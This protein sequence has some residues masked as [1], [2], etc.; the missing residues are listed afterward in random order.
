MNWQDRLNPQAGGA[1][2]HLHE[3]FGRIAR[4]HQV[5]L[6]VSRWPGAPAR[7]QVDGMDV[8]RAGGRYTFTFAGPWYYRRRLRDQGFDV[9]VEDLN[10]IPL[11]TPLWAQHPLALVVHHLFGTTAFQEAR[12]PLA[13]ATVLAELPLGRVY[14]SVPAMA[15]SQSTAHDLARRGLDPDRIE[16]VPNGVDLAW[17][18]PDPSVPRF[19][20]PTLLYLGRLKRYKRVDLVLRALAELERRGLDVR[21]FV[22]GAGDQAGRLTAVAGRLGV[23]DRVVFTGFVSEE[24]KRELFRRAWVHV[25][26]SPKEGWGITNLE[27]AA[28]GTPTVASDAP[29]LRDSVVDGETGLL[30]PHGDVGSLADALERLLEDGDLRARMGRNARR[31]AEGFTWNRSADAT[32]RFLEGVAAGRS[33]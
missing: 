2:A 30:V 3:I 26:T 4:D 33:D 32:L 28:C 15:V 8:H 9:M 31:F 11:Y 1:E 22:A 10:K 18:A 20:E 12:P 23:A 14:R 13:T 17:Y 29:G 24:R 16:V 7:Q 25:L 5:T 19:D 21:L 6:L 27:A